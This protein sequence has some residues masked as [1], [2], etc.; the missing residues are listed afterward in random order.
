M[1]SSL[2]PDVGLWWP[3]AARGESV[4][5][6]TLILFSTNPTIIRQAV[7]SGVGGIIVDWEWI[8]KGQRQASADTQI[9]R[10]T[11]DD[12]RRV[13]ACTDALVICRINSYGV[14][15]AEEVEQVIEAGADE[16]LLPM[17]Q[18]VEEVETVLEQVKSRCGVGILIET[19]A[20]VRLVEDL[21]RLPL[22]RVYVGL[23]DLAIERTSPNIFTP[24][25]DGTLERLRHHVHVPF[26]FGGLTLPDRGHPIPCRLLIGEMAR[27]NC[28]FSF[29]RRSF[30]RDIEGRDPAD[31]LPRLL[32]S[33]RQAGLRP[34]LAVTQDRHELA[35]F[36]RAWANADTF[37]EERS[38]DG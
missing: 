12:L 22:S 30:Y 32:E 23:N 24:L 6:F 38:K 36:I 33:L 9:N 19:M 16:I 17:V 13:R 27:L 26:G 37:V 11:L 28:D 15:T 3:F 29:L 34:P 8:G 1:T 31:E 20:A 35:T 25:V 7:P 2:G 5:R 18:T 21:G 10:D 4:P 14:V